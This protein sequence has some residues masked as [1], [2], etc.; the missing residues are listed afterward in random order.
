[1]K[2][3][4]KAT[5]FCSFLNTDWVQGMQEIKIWH[6][7][8]KREGCQERWAVLRPNS[9]IMRKGRQIPQLLFG[10]P[11]VHPWIC[12]WER[13]AE[14]SAE[15]LGES[16]VT[17][18]DRPR[19]TLWILLV[20]IFSCCKTWKLYKGHRKVM[21]VCLQG[22]LWSSE[23]FSEAFW[24]WLMGRNFYEYSSKI[25]NPSVAILL[26]A[27]WKEYKREMVS[28][29]KQRQNMNAYKI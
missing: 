20:P 4:E 8:S 27:A 12:V 26:T 1:M 7:D 9:K 28:L 13:T 24:Y 29:W 3:K 22:R 5:L 23:H 17:L 25:S 15:V 14:I 21:V 10:P 16:K 11:E 19:G 2:R 18:H 6:T